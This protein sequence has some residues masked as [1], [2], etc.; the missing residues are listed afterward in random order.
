MPKN[1]QAQTTEAL[2]H[3]GNDANA[4]VHTISDQNVAAH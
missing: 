2:A 3:N 4:V 1:V